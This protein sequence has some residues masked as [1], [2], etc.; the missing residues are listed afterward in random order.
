MLSDNFHTLYTF[1][2]FS[3]FVTL[4]YIFEDVYRW[5]SPTDICSKLYS[6]INHVE[7]LE[8]ITLLAVENK[9]EKSL[10]GETQN[11]SKEVKKKKNTSV[12]SRAAYHWNIDVP[13]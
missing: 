12:L 2:L 11:S 5:R 6:F 1:C 7:A 10:L 4:I 9:Q 8:G 3:S 13:L